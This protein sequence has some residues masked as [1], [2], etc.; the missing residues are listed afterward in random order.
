[1]SEQ[2]QIIE[3]LKQA[4]SADPLQFAPDGKGP[5]DEVI[6]K[7]KTNPDVF[8]TYRSFIASEEFVRFAASSTEHA[9]SCRHLVRQLGLSSALNAAALRRSLK[10]STQ[11]ATRAMLLFMLRDRGAL[12][13]FAEVSEDKQLLSQL[14]ALG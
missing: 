1:M 14:A 5:I 12:P 8:D 6:L 11:V 3:A 4:I 13:S 9:H 7:A 2:T 10:A